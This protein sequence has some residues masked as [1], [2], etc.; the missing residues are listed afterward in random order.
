MSGLKF[1]SISYLL[2]EFKIN[3]Q[4]RIRILSL[5]NSYSCGL[6]LHYIKYHT[7]KKF[8]PIKVCNTGV[9]MK[10]CAKGA[11]LM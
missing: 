6:F 9:L 2:F 4:F 11:K 8:F 10:S 1:V 3:P 7:L 5:L